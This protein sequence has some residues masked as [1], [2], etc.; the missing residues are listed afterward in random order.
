MAVAETIPSAGEL[1]ARARDLRPRLLERQE[2]T[3]ELTYY[4]PSTH[5][6]FLQ[7]GLY[8]TLQP[9]RYGGW[10]HDVP[11]F[12]R[13]IM[14]VARGCPST[15]W[16]LCLSSAHVL[17][18][19]TLFGERAQ[20]EILAGDGDFRAAS[21]SG[22]VGV[23]V[24]LKEGFLLDGT[25]PYSSGAP[26]STH[27]LGQ[28]TLAPR[29]PDHP[30][31]PMLLFVIPRSQWELVDDWHG[32][33]G[34]RGSGSHSVRISRQVVPAHHVV[35]RFMVDLDVEGGTPG[36]RLHG[37]PMYAGRATG[38]F[39]LEFAAITVGAAYA[40]LDEYERII[41]T[42]AA[43]WAPTMKRYELAEYQRHLGRAMGR[44]A[45]AEAATLGLAEQFMQLCRRS[46]QDGVAF[47]REDDYRLVMAGIEVG[48]LVWHTVEGILFHTGGSAGARDGQRLQRYFRDLATY[49]SHNTAAQE[50]VLAE[51]LGRLHLGLPLPPFGA[52]P[53]A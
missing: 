38:F 5:R 43:A 39:T 12:C 15:G 17:Q 24:P 35:E 11:T 36:Y 22:P 19:A 6:D 23:A 26:Y 52:P 7:A 8:R 31:G 14:E 18:V 49:W 4:P 41:S 9:R 50:E 10:E 46:V 29:Q 25:W 2:E 32:V 53:G 33:L 13:V 48:R 44:V 42:R 27:F 45:A 40:A 3:E 37:N 30:P 21:F 28:T 34:L 51:R 16:C 20:S 47:S 1:V